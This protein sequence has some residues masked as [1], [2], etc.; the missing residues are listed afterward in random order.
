MA[1]KDF[2]ITSIPMVELQNDTH[3]PTVVFY[4]EQNKISI[5][6][7]AKAASKEVG[8][9]LLN[10]DFKID[11]GK[12]DP[13]HGASKRRFP[14]ANG[15][16]KSAGEITGDFLDQLLRKVREWLPAG[17]SEENAG[18]VIAEPLTMQGVDVDE[19]WLGNYRATIRRILTGKGFSKDRIDFMPEPF[20]VFQYYKYGLKHPLLGQGKQ[21]ALVLDFGGGSFDVCIIES[22]REGE[23]SGKRKNTRPLAAASAPVGGFFINRI[24]AE[25]LL[26]KYA[27]GN[28]T[29]LTEIGKGLK[30]YR[31]WRDQ[32][33]T[34]FDPKTI[35]T[36][37]MI[38]A[39]NFHNLIYEVEDPKLALCNAITDWNLD[40]VNNISVPVRLPRDVFVDKPEYFSATLTVTEFK[41]AFVQNVWNS[42]MRRI[43]RDALE[44][45]H[46]ELEGSITVILLSGGS[47]NI[48]WVQ[49]LLFNEFGAQ[50][51]DAQV[52]EL[53]DDFQ[54]VVAKGVAVECA[55]RFYDENSV[56]DFTSITYNRVHL[57]L[58]P[59]ETN[60]QLKQFYP[61]ADNPIPRTKKPGVLIPSA[62][63]LRNQF[64]KPLRWDVQLDKAPK[65][66]LD[67][68]FL[69]KGFTPTV[70]DDGD[71]S[72]PA[73]YSEDLLN[74]DH[75]VYTPAGCRFDSSIGVEMLVEKET[76]TSR[77][78]FIYCRDTENRKGISV[79]GTPFY[80]DITDTQDN[81]SATSY[82][83]LDFGTSNTSVSFISQ[84]GIQTYQKRVADKDWLE[85]NVLYNSLPF[86]LAITLAKYLS[87][88]DS[89][90]LVDYAR[91]FFEAALALAAY[92]SYL[93]MCLQK[94][95]RK[96][97]FLKGFQQRSIGP[98][99]ALLRNS[100]NELGSEADISAAFQALLKGFYQEV[101]SA[102]T[103]F[104]NE[105]HEKVDASS[106]N[107][108][109]VKIIGNV[110]RQAFTQQSFG[111]FEGVQQ[112]RFRGGTFKGR[113]RV[114]SGANARFVEAEPYL[115]SISF[116][117]GEAYLVNFQRRLA[118]PLHP[119]VFWYSCEKHGE[120]EHCYFYDI[121]EGPK[122]H[123]SFSFKA[124]GYP[125][126]LS[127]STEDSMLGPIAC[128]LAV[129]VEEDPQI[130]IMKF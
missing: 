108:H 56:G 100:L 1:D 106:F 38:F 33:S 123:K 16:S 53:E 68:Y 64:N 115:G 18:I 4:G 125:C 88:Q 46:G 41:D 101:N 70:E 92:T 97:Q 72:V 9:E 14:T 50:L 3:I 2:F 23:V 65:K 120:E 60:L 40:A 109:V 111:M 103:Y 11:I 94:K 84:K 20:A 130:Q 73:K 91:E 47:C 13:S 30:V 87:G 37:L 43:I 76:K 79:Q 7:E 112:E 48:R 121:P 89:S 71:R 5:G 10:E 22:D 98:L 26:R 6:Y 107:P 77:V 82:I 28:K 66:R 52:L 93:E 58:D 114:A 63:I 78:K 51:R 126:S 85:L 24:I 90:Q 34:N 21:R 35:K 127:V 54:E 118:L 117:N 55:R 83:G 74:I 95:R 57:V 42:Q 12:D 15:I 128:E 105:K 61:E 31:Q 44:R 102:V 67:Y 69:R 59:D 19:T 124:A 25:K 29:Q 119:L 129:Y 122:P 17:P 32:Q 81:P 8:H 99:W 104:G 27:E 86:P 49:P 116:P 36:N 80:L 110:S 113:F 96:T 39:R 75:T 62:S 45:G